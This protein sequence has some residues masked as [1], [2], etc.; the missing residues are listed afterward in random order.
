MSQG[1]R[2]L[3][4]AAAAVPDGEAYCDELIAALIAGVKKYDPIM[5][6]GA[7]LFTYDLAASHAKYAAAIGK[8]A[9]DLYGIERHVAPVSHVL[10]QGQKGYEGA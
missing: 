8:E 5:S 7:E 1:L 4:L 3:A 10:A 2:D 6:M 9:D